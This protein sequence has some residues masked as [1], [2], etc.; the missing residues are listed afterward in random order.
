MSEFFELFES[1]EDFDEFGKGIESSESLLESNEAVNKSENNKAFGSSSTGEIDEAD[2]KDK[3]GGESTAESTGTLAEMGKL[4]SSSV[5]F[6][7]GDEYNRDYYRHQA[8]LHKESAARY[9][10]DAAHDRDMA[11]RYADDN[12][13]KAASYLSSARNWESKASSE[14]SA[15]SDDMRKSDSY[16]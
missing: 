5:S 14:R 9:A 16:S 15:A 8:E 13:E 6:K 1:D 11:E 7:G 12:P 4:G 3:K 2:E 10:R